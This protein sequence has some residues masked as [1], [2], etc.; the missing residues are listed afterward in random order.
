M[1]GC[2]QAPR[3]VVVRAVFQGQQGAGQRV[4]RQLGLVDKDR[5]VLVGHVRFVFQAGQ[6]VGQGRRRRR[7]V[8]GG[9]G[10]GGRWGRRLGVVRVE[11]PLGVGLRRRLPLGP[12]RL[13]HLADLV[14][15]GV[16]VDR[17]AAGLFEQVDQGGQLVE[18]EEHQVDHLGADGQLVLARRVE[19]VLD[20][21]GQVVDVAQPE[22]GRQPL[23]AVGGAEHVVEQVLVATLLLVVER[24]DPL[25]QLQ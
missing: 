16:A 25:V 9:L 8:G 24:A 10:L 20:L 17:L 21:V 4:E 1:G 19:D 6:R 22:H 13:E 23:E 14:Q 5:Q 2:H 15:D 12:G 3:R 11:G 7:G 18:A